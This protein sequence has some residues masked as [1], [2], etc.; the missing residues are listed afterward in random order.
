MATIDVGKIKFVWKGA[1]AAGTTYSADDVVSYNGTSWIY[2]NA[3]AASGQTPAD[4]AYWDI[5]ADGANPMTTPGDM[6]FGGSGGTS[7]RLPI[8]AS[9]NVLKVTS[10]TTVGWGTTSG[11]EGLKPLGTNIPLFAHT[12]DSNPI[13]KWPWL[14]RYSGKSGASADYIP[15]DGMPNGSCSPIKRNKR[16]NRNVTTGDIFYFINQNYELVHKGSSYQG[17]IGA[18]PDQINAYTSLYAPIST[19]FG[20]MSAGEYFV[21]VWNRFKSN[22]AMTN[23][24]NLWVW[25]ENAQ[26][27]LGLGD[28]VNRNQWVRNPYLGPQATNNSITCEIA[29]FAT[30]GNET[31]SNSTYMQNFAILHDGRVLG[32]GNNAS[33]SLGV[34]D[35]VVTTIPELVTSLSGVDIISIEGGV[36]A[37]YF[38]DSAG[39]IW[40]TG[41]NQ[42][43][44]GKGADRQ[45]PIIMTGVDN[46]VQFAAHFCDSYSS[47][48][49]TQNDGDSY[50]IGYNGYGQLGLGDTTNRA[51]WTQT[52][53][54]LNFAAV[55]FDGTDST[56]SS[57]AL[58]GVPGDLFDT[59]SGTSVYGCGYNAYGTLGIGNTTNSTAWVQPSVTSWG[60]SYFKTVTTADGSTASSSNMVFPRTA[61][62]YLF[63]T[64]SAEGTNCMTYVDMQGRMWIT[65]YKYVDYGYRNSTGTI[66]VTLPY[67]Y[68]SPWMHTLSSGEWYNGAAQVTIE[69]YYFDT[70]HSST[71]YN[72]LWLRTSDGNI[73]F[74]GDQVSAVGGGGGITGPRVHWVRMGV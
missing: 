62:K 36:S 45:S 43:G 24:G 15:Y 53:G 51:A 37:T 35:A 30:C 58:T 60:T 64:P 18:T 61:I 65:G 67:P 72:N 59:T 66:A 46:V 2:V 21:R 52:G 48:I 13:I 71:T 44:I 73:W 8:G 20:G 5:M 33:G 39:A 57:H 3:S 31:D 26:G 14:A 50:A 38:L 68:P 47:V 49:A 29:Y 40:H 6:I 54:S 69:D 22:F 23:K 28:V 11:L 1:Y 27:Q 16:Y 19:E 7:T 25:G 56:T 9:S 34:G 70:S 41:T 17:G 74:M 32:W 42:T 4:N 12:T 63:P 10:G 55:W